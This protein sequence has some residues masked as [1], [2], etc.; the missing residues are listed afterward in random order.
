MQIIKSK[1]EEGLNITIITND[2]DHNLFSDSDNNIV[3][4]L[5]SKMR[6]SGI[7]VVLN[8]DTDQCFAIVDDEI[9]WYGGINLLGKEDIRDNLIRIKDERITA[10]LLENTI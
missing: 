7:N 6:K 9:V 2:P 1:Q 4:E 5:I 3:L 8:D 10:E